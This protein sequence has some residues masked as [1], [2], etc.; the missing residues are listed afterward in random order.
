MTRSVDTTTLSL[1]LRTLG[2]AAL[3]SDH[4]REPILGPGK[5]LALLI[6]IALSPGR[7]AS[8]ESLIDLL[9]TD[10]GLDRARNSLRQSL[11]QLRRVTG[12]DAIVGTEELMLARAIAVDRD[13]FLSALDGGDIQ[14]A[15]DVYAGTFL[16]TFGVPGGAGF[17]QWA[18]LER[19]RLQAGFVRAGEM[20]VRRLLNDSR[21]DAGKQLAKLVRERAPQVEAA[22][23]LLLEA[24][25]ASRDFVLAAMEA[26]ALEQWA[27]AEQIALESSTRTAIA[28]ARRVASSA[29]ATSDHFELVAELTGREREFFAITSAW[30]AVRSGSARHLHLSAPPGFGKTR[31]LRDALTRLSASGATVVHA[32]GKAGD[33]DL[34]YA[35]I[36]DLA[37][38]IAAL[39]GAAGISSGSMAT[40]LALNPALSTTFSGPA[41]AASGADALRRRMLAMTDLVHSVAHERRFVLAI[42]DLH[43]IDAP[44]YR[45]LE[46]IWARIDSA[47]VLCLTASRPERIPNVENCTRL[48]LPALSRAQVGALVAG[49]GA[50]PDDDGMN[51]VFIVGLHD[52]TDGSP[53]LVLETLRFAM[54][55]GMLQLSEGE[56]RIVD[57]ARLTTLLRAGEAVRERI[58]ALSAPLLFNLAILAAAGTVLDNAMLSAISETADDHLRSQLDQLDRMGLIVR[59]AN[60]V[61]P[62]HDEIALAALDAVSSDT[63]ADIERRIGTQFARAS[64]DPNDVLRA[65][66]HVMAAGDELTV[67]HVFRDYVQRTRTRGDRRS[68]RALASDFGGE[69]EGLDRTESLVRALPVSWRLGLWSPARR[70]AAVA[71]AVTVTVLCFSLWRA[72]GTADNSTQRLLMTD[73]TR[74]VLKLDVAA[75]AWNNQSGPVRMQT[76][77]AMFSDAAARSPDVAPAISPDGRSVAWTQDS[78]DSTTLDIWIRTER[79][80]RRLTRQ[81]RD[82]KVFGWL[83]D[84]SALVGVTDRWSTPGSLGYD[85]AVFDTASGAARQISRGMDHDGQPQASPDGTRIAFL[86]ESNEFP[87]RLCVVSVDGIGEAECR[88]VNGQPIAQFVG[89]SG[90]DELVVL[91]DGPD[92]RPLIAYDWARNLSREILGPFG[93]QPRLSPDRRW[94][95]ASLRVAGVQGLRDWVAPLDH[96]GLARRIENSAYRSNR[97]WEGPRDS[98]LLI[99]RIEFDDTTQVIPLGLGSRLRIRSLTAANIEVPLRAPLRWLTSDSTIAKIDSTGEVRPLRSGDVTITAS[100]AAWRHVSKRLHVAGTTS[101]IVLDERWDDSWE[102]RWMAWGEP[103]PEVVIGPGGTRAFWNHG[104]GVFSSYGVLR[105]SYS[106]RQGLGTEVRVSTPTTGNSWQRLR[107]SLVAGLDTALLVSGDQR[108]APASTGDVDAICT[109]GFPGP[110]RWAKNQIA[111]TASTTHRLDLTPIVSTATTGAWWTIRLQILP[112]GRCGLAINGR[113]LWISADALS[114][115]REYRVRLGDESVDAKLLHGPLQL[116]VGVR[117]DID[118]TGKH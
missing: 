114:L 28:R 86:R 7:R 66:R 104:D 34:P 51:D 108:K 49:L 94:V 32:R 60:G 44:S 97:W 42:D 23:R 18:D 89:W 48:S 77:R 16:P 40:L 14:G 81:L 65:A 29:D 9:W 21:L 2:T 73:S 59:N 88:L 91:S 70:G 106:A 95:V 82:D 90:L 105:H 62:T 39:P 43:W 30:E 93:S 17:E 118:W 22:A 83:P 50:L 24:A 68:L 52:A 117:T 71:A 27:A 37:A 55:Q 78:G 109:V 100:L 101:T 96:P 64:R 1:R 98:S 110:G 5:P 67:R 103:R 102:S 36:S 63:R 58:R 46:A 20:Q 47:R 15:I 10:V 35:F 113:P 72:L 74:S 53:L 76:A 99:D 11:F 80:E 8:R 116:W 61:A 112:D 4:N 111:V 85:V 19:D 56:W 107:L 12:E 54:D 3:V 33:R 84:G 69:H 79:G 41:D 38:T 26:N 25:V 6:F 57:R 13:E 92:K 75:G 115:D 87:P 31:L 45:V